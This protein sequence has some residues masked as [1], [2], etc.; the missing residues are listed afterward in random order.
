MRL[1]DHFKGIV[2]TSY[3][4][5]IKPPLFSQLYTLIYLAKLKLKLVVSICL[6]VG[7]LLLYC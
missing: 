7:K 1:V 5:C 4:L 3:I 2:I 6:I